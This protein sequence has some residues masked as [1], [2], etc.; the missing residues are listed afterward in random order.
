MPGAVNLREDFSA[1]ELR[2]RT[3]R[4][5]LVTRSRVFGAGSLIPVTNAIEALNAKLRRAVRTRGHFLTDEAAIKLLYLVFRQVDGWQ[6]LAE[7]PDDQ[8]IDLAA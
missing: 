8:I 5:K 7:K 4:R 3:I 1:A 6:T 2:A